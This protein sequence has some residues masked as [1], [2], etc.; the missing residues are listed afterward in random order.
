MRVQLVHWNA[1]EIAQRLERLQAAGYEATGQIPNGPDFVRTLRADPPDAV[2][3]D[4]SRLPSQGR[5][6]GMMLRQAK[7]T[8]YIPLVFVGG[9]PLKV[10]KV[11]EQIPDA[12]YTT[13]DEIHPAL[14]Q[15]IF[16]P[17]AAPTAPKT[18]FDSYI[19][20][21]LAQ[22][23]GLRPGMRLGLVAPP[24]DFRKT[25]GEVPEGVAVEDRAEGECDVLLWFIRT[26]L[27]LEQGVGPTSARPDFRFLWIIWPKKASGVETDL[28]QPLVRE[29]G[30]AAGLVD[31]KICSVDATWTGLEFTRRKK[32]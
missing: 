20:R 19:G 29:A 10:E 9:D 26:R 1:S 4:L 27:D 13:W 11:K 18:L 31:F 12:V 6:F 25:L 30:L 17:P 32:D 2:V 24:P 7:A 14:E 15:A 23:L 8:R 16:H 22:K 28:T 5:D 3:I 21:P